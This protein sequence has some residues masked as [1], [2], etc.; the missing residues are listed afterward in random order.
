MHRLSWCPYFPSNATRVE[1]HSAYRALRSSDRLF[2][3]RPGAGHTGKIVLGAPLFAA[4][5]DPENYTAGRWLHHDKL[6]REAR[7]IQFNFPALCKKAL[8][9]TPGAETVVDCEKL[10]GG[11][12]RSFIFTM[13]NDSKVVARL[14][15][16]VAGPPRLT[17][18]SEVATMSFCGIVLDAKPSN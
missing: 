4:G 15:T 17:T 1:S 14:P 11:F 3:Q 6:Q 8:A 10:E 13:D 7:R 16:R 12:N 5:M 9:F 2:R 18:N